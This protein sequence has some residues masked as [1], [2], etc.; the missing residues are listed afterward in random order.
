MERLNDIQKWV[1]NT[2]YDGPASTERLCDILVDNVKQL[3]DGDAIEWTADADPGGDPFQ[4]DLFLS[5]H[6]DKVHRAI[7][8][9]EL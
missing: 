4:A 6:G 7:Q 9:G 1:V 2:L 3:L 8:Q 5:D